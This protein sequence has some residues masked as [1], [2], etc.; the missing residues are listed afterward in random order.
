MAYVISVLQ[1]Q[2][3]SGLQKQ[4]NTI[5]SPRVLMLQ[6][7]MQRAVDFFPVLL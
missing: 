2:L 6:K 3:E 4:P 7:F 5:L 1:K